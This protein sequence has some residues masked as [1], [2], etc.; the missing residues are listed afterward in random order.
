M[1]A[2]PRRLGTIA[3]AV[4]LVSLLGLSAPVRAA[5]RAAGKAYSVSATVRG[6]QNLTVLLVSGTGRTLA[7]QKIT[8]ASQKVSL[9]SPNISN[10]AGA[11]LQLVSG[12]GGKSKGA[13]FG[14]VVLGWKGKSSAS[15]SK[16]YTKLKSSAGTRL[17]L[18]TMSIK[19]VG[20]AKQGFAV[21]AAASKAADSA[22]T[23][24]V[25]ASKGRPKGVG[26]YG[27]TASVAGAE[28]GV[29]ATGFIQTPN[30]NPPTNPTVAPGSP[31][32]PTVA[33]GQPAGPP[34]P[35]QPGQPAGPAGPANPAQPG[36]PAQPGAGVG[37]PSQDDTLGGDKDDDGL[38]NAFD[39]DDDGDG[40][41][42]SAD[43]T[44][45]TPTVSADNGTADCGAITWRIFTNYKATGDAYKGTINAYGTGAFEATSASI[46]STIGA[47]MSMVFQPITTVCGSAVTKSYIKGNG[48]PYAPADYVEV[49]KTCNTGDYQ[50]LIGA[51]RMC[52]TDGTGYD[53]GSKYTFSGTD[54]PT[55]QDTFTMKVDTA[56]GKSY[57][58]TS[59]PGFVFVTHP[60]FISYNDGTGE[61]QVQYGAPSVNISVAKSTVLTLKMYRPQRLA[62]DGESGT[63]YDLGGFKVSPDIPN[64]IMAGQPGQPNPTSQP[65]QGPGKCDAQAVTDTEMTSD[66]PINTSTKPTMTIKWELGKCF[67]EKSIAWSAGSLTVDIQV[68]PSGPGG[69]AAQKLF[70]TTTQ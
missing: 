44:T 58:F 67:D 64:G 10:A 19:K 32:N 14:P 2:T 21:L 56:D 47:T 53:F 5:V 65:S 57:E 37:A 49:G 35:A 9:K 22:A 45:P 13:Y 24:Q 6:G 52:S 61:K 34:N 41:I 70:L 29:S 59:S 54:L 48:A 33:P 69:N 12:S 36:Q 30:P 17:S 27:K 39:V 31:T 40:I 16:V 15:A 62:I 7:S 3:I 43:S 25:S 55:G 63:F 1:S 18:G 38:L 66:Q 4:T 20:T 46:A 23:A 42:D 51:G 26:T 8:K 60:M 28:Y 11:T 50:W 68:E